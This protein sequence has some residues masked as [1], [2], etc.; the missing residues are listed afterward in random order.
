MCGLTGYWQPAG[1]DEGAAACV[2]AM[3]VTLVHRG[4]DDAG[5]WLDAENGIALAHRRLAIVDLSPA[6][7]QPMHSASR[8][9][10]LVFNGEIYNHAHL[11]QE[12]ERAGQAPDWRG[13]SDTETL[14]ACI[15]AWGLERTLRASIGMFAIALWDRAERMLYLARDRMGEKPLYCG[16]QGDTF[17][18]GS[19]LKALVAHPAFRRE[20]DRDAMALLLRYNYIP[21]PHSIWRG[22]R[23]LTPGTWLAVGH[24][25]RDPEPVPYWSLKEVAESGHR[26]LLPL[27]IDA[28]SHELERVLSLSV[29]MQMVAD[30]PLGALLSGGIDSSAI[31]ALMQAQSSRPVRTFSIGFHEKAFDESAHAAAVARHLGTDHTELFMSAGDVLDAVSRMPAMYDEPFAD[32]S[33]LPTALVM[34]LARQQVTVAI[35]GDGGDEL[36]GGYNRYPLAPRVWNLLRWLR[37]PLRQALGRLLTGVSPRQWDRLAAPLARVVDQAHAGDKLHK[38]GHRLQHLR[39]PDDLYL[40]LVTEWNDV[41]PMAVGASQAPTLLAQC[42]DWPQLDDPVSRMMALDAMTY[43]PDDILV[44]VD[45][46]AMAASLETRAPFLDHR[47]VEFAWRLPLEH[48]VA[49]GQGKRVLRKLLYRHVPQGLVERPKAGFQIPLDDW[50]RNELRD[51]AETLLAPEALQASGLLEVAPVRMAWEQHLSGTRS[52]GHRLWSVL[53][54][55]AW[56]QQEQTT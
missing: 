8:R 47:V 44:K 20:I 27:N 40:A 25:A 50:L 46:A 51:W 6:G 28:A 16:W 18:F 21:A 9:H 19:E 38:L 23:K 45:R 42:D 56:W 52:F 29:G 36:F 13:H 43:L 30:V 12:L 2:T 33:Q 26:N 11:R 53:M 10:V 32:S 3:A 35:S 34:A 49:G 1:L 15:E 41:G 55:Q 24:E 31:V 5:D 17:L 39:S 54:L 48:R 7:H 22:I 37:T 4:P 14:L